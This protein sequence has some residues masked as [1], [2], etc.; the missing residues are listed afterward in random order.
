MSRVT[1]PA[2]NKA[3]R[4]EGINA[5][6]VRGKDYFWFDG[7]DVEWAESPSVMTCYISDLTLETWLGEARRIRDESNARNPYLQEQE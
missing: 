6:L 5:E 7:P 3:L 4:A 1:I 2:V